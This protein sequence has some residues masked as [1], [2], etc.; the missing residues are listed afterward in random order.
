MTYRTRGPA[1]TLIELLVVIAIIAILVAILLPALGSARRAARTVVCQSN[2]RQLGVGLA[3]YGS[4]SSERIATFSWQIHTDYGW[5]SSG[6]PR[7]AAA[8][9][10]YYLLNAATGRDDFQPRPTGSS[11]SQPDW[12]PHLAL[13]YLVMGEH[14]DSPGPSEAIAC[15][16]D[17]LRRLWQTAPESFETLDAVERPAGPGGDLAHWPYTSSYELVP[18]AF[19]ADVGGGNLPY[20]TTTQQGLEHDQYATQKRPPL[21]TR[22]L[23]HVTFPAMKIAMMD[24]HD[25]HASKRPLFYA[26]E[27]AQQPLLFFDGHVATHR[28]V[29]ANRGFRP[30]NAANPGPTL[31]TYAPDA[32]EP[33]TN[34]GARTERVF[35]MYRWTRG[36]LTG[37]DFGGTEVSTEN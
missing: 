26:Y 2:M 15:P 21:G 32:W 28:T 5:G 31:M 14:M 16:E 6:T 9:Q 27:G 30:N 8:N 12:L 20:E 33:E 23:D 7:A 13:S 1:F 17:R 35:G 22:T 19:S 25:R 11:L 29:D 10:A 37:V 4:D 18:A 3:S 36:G 24:T 34:N